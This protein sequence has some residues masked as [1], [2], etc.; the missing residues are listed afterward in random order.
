[1][2]FSYLLLGSMAAAAPTAPGVVSF[3]VSKTK[4][5]PKIGFTSNP[6]TYYKAS[7][8]IGTPAQTFDVILDTGSSDLWVPN[9]DSEASST[10]ELINHDF[11]ASYTAFYLL[12]DW[13]RESVTVGP[14][15]LEKFQFGNIKTKKQEQGVFGISFKQSE[16]LVEPNNKNLFYDNF[17]YAAKKAGYTKKAAYSIFL[18]DPKSN[19]GTFLLGGVDHAKFEGDLVW[20]Q[21]EDPSWGAEVQLNSI[22]I[23]S[24]E[25]A[26]NN[27]TVPDTGTQFTTL[28]DESFQALKQE[29]KLGDV[30]RFTGLNYIDCDAK[31]KLDFNFPG[32]TVTSD[33]SS[34]ILK[35]A[36]FTGDDDERCLFGVQSAERWGGDILLGDTFM[37]NAYVV[38]NLEDNTVGIAQAVYTD[39]TDVK[40]L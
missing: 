26:V 7:V 22:T 35:V 24:K 30:N 27:K 14:V 19:K 10:Y 36:D 33:E 3:A 29:L 5:D 38:Y 32:K 28:P 23:N 8:S 17:P 13:A 11:N 34:L 37:R 21:V 39:K 40:P 18:N 25:V 12:G 15:S 4:E 16:A 31:M 2:L 20:L 9:F 6:G 1:M